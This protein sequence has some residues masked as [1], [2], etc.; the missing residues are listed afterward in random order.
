MRISS[1]LLLPL[2]AVLVGCAAP[3]N[4]QKDQLP[5]YF[6]AV[7]RNIIDPLLNQTETCTTDC[8]QILSAAAD[9]SELGR[10]IDVNA[11]NRNPDLVLSRVNSEI[12]INNGAAKQAEIAPALDIATFG[13]TSAL[14][15]YV[16]Q[17]NRRY[18]REIA[19]AHQIDAANPDLVNNVTANGGAGGQSSSSSNPTLN[20]STTANASANPSV[21]H[22]PVTNVS[23]QQ[24]QIQD[25]SLNNSNNLTANPV[26]NSGS[27]SGAS[28]DSTSLVDA[29]FLLE[30]NLRIDANGMIVPMAP[31]RD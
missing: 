8:L 29:N 3:G 26:A 1:I 31:P 6:Q 13:V 4:V 9:A 11:V 12:S 24:G 7:E 23:N 15:G 16:A 25:Q 2:F 17:G 20:N 14:A 28:A 27:V 22:N 10:R 19:R 5:T 21:T 30:N 18:Q